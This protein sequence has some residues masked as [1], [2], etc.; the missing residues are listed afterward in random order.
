MPQFIAIKGRTGGA[1]SWGVYPGTSTGYGGQY[2][3]K[4]NETSSAAATAI[5]WDNTDATS[6]VFTVTGGSGQVGELGVNYVA[7]CW[8]EVAGYSKI[9]RYTGNGSTDGSFVWCG[10]KPAFVLV[11]RTDSTSQWSIFDNKREG[12]NVDNDVLVV[13]TAAAETTTDYLD[14]LSNG[15]KARTTDANV[16]ASGGTYI[17]MAIAEHPFGGSSVAPVP[18]R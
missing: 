12:Y 18:A 17:F 16:N 11:K 8:A 7:Y 9:G 4:L 3:L 13:N 10:F 6:S 5:Y 1:D 15:F 14:L 2:R